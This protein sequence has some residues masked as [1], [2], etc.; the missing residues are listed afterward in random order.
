MGAPET[1]APDPACLSKNIA[2]FYE[3]DDISLV[4]GFVRQN[5]LPL[6]IT[7]M[8]LNLSVETR[9]KINIGHVV[10]SGAVVE[11]KVIRV[12]KKDL[13]IEKVFVDWFDMCIA[14]QT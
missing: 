10:E 1:I 6:G 9:S 8:V 5:E 13:R 11:G 14:G 2:H 12:V 4:S 7:E 3:N